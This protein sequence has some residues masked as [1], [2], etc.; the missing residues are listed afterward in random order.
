MLYRYST[1][2]VVHLHWALGEVQWGVVY[3]FKS[4]QYNN[5]KTMEF[6][7]E[8]EIEKHTPNWRKVGGGFVN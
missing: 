5:N 3:K 1:C 7:K 6:S 2:G 8:Q 4:T